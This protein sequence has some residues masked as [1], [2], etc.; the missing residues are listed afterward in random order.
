LETN[1]SPQPDEFGDVAINR[2]QPSKSRL[3]WL[4]LINPAAGGGK[5]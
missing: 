5:S 3:V 4:F 1:G 2:N